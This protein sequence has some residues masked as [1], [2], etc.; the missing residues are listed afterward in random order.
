MAL[1]AIASKVASTV[2][3][4]A[5]GAV[6]KGVQGAR[7]VGNGI[8]GGINKLKNAKQAAQQAADLAKQK[9]KKVLLIKVGIP[10]VALFFLLGSVSLILDS[11]FGTSN[12][13]IK[14]AS[15][16]V[17]KGITGDQAQID[18]AIELQ[19]KYDSNIGFTLDQISQLATIGMGQLD[20]DSNIYAAYNAKYGTITEEQKASPRD[21]YDKFNTNGAYNTDD[22]S[23]LNATEENFLNWWRNTDKGKYNEYPTVYDREKLY[24]HILMTE[25]YNFNEITW[26]AHNHN[27]EENKEIEKKDLKLDESLGLYYPTKGNAKLDDFIDL[28]SPYLLSSQVPIA[29]TSASA[30]SNNQSGSLGS[31]SYTSFAEKENGKTNNFGDFAY[32]IIKHAMSD[33]EIGQFNLESYAESTYWRDYNRYSCHDTATVTEVKREIDLP[34]QYQPQSY[35]SPFGTTTTISISNY[36][37]GS[38]ADPSDEAHKKYKQEVS[39]RTANH[40]KESDTNKADPTLE[41]RRGDPVVSTATKYKLTYALAFDVKVINSYDYIRYSDENRDKRVE[42]NYTK[43]S[44]TNDFFK[45]ESR[46][47]TNDNGWYSAKD[48]PGSS[49]HVT[50]DALNKCR[51]MDQIDDKGNYTQIGDSV[52]SYETVDGVRYRVTT[53]KYEFTSE[54]YFCQE[55]TESGI[56]RVWSDSLSE[57]PEKSTKTMLSANDVASFNRNAKEDISMS[58]VETKDFKSSSASME[59]YNSVAEDETTS[60][61]TVDFT[62][63]NPKVILN[64]LSAS[65]K[66]SIY[67]GYSKYDYV[68]TQ[69][70]NMLYDEFLNLKDKNENQVLPFEYGSSLGFEVGATRAK[71]VSEY[72]SPLMLL[73]DMLRTYNDKPEMRN[74]SYRKTNLEENCKYYEVIKKNGKLFVGH[75]LYISDLTNDEKREMLELIGTEKIEEGDLIDKEIVDKYEEQV[76]KDYVEKVENA[77]T[78][79]ELKDH[80]VHALVARFY[81]I[82]SSYLSEQTEGG[83]D[84]LSAYNTYW[85]E[86]TD[87][88]YDTLKEEDKEQKY[89][90]SEVKSK[91]NFENEMYK[92]YFINPQNDSDGNSLLDRRMDEYILF[93]A[94]YYYPNERFYKK[95]SLGP[96]DIDLYNSD[97]TVNEEACIELQNWFHENIFDGSDVIAL[98]DSIQMWR[99]LKWTDND[100]LHNNTVTHELFKATTE[101]GDRS[102]LGLQLFQCTWWAESRASLYLVE[103]APDLFPNGI[104]GYASGNGVDVAKS[105]ADSTGAEFNTDIHNIEPNSVVSWHTYSKEYPGCGHVGYVEAVDKD[106][107]YYYV[108]EAG[109]GHAWYGIQKRSMDADEADFEGSVCLDDVIEAKS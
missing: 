10:A 77:T 43:D 87:D 39:T 76:I 8:K 55:G 100:S 33:I 2:G 69:A 46:K 12:G 22:Y 73:R 51:N 44:Y 92:N 101:G 66:Y 27:E 38:T 11:L 14:F 95:S 105:I 68:M 36:V 99:G 108:S 21:F 37:D 109:G 58:T 96:G 90:A 9:I 57:E 85:N 89:T 31:D 50:K 88:L 23:N 62:N 3:K 70:K 81:S 52:T 102:Y 26:S 84:F 78:S 48:T 60:I 71:A 94:G 79:V 107:G 6:Q 63:A 91:V 19:E 98:E 54:E 103:N 61:N 93:S 1:A 65:Q 106:N 28:V 56:T 15:G 29:F 80:Q 74:A 47:E 4:A 45:I 97:G 82:G 17:K 41:E 53:T 64:Y 104:K 16:E 34:Y 86:E 5:S 7:N 30:Y 42:E 49:N 35:Y 40:E 13:S 83:L 75:N 72:I 67:V 59:Y 32:Q 18:R 20:K 25:K 24:K